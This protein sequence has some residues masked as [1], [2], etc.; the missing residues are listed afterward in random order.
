MMPFLMMNF[1]T[2]DTSTAGFYDRIIAARLLRVLFIL[3][4]VRSCCS[5]LIKENRGCFAEDLFGRPVGGDP[6]RPALWQD[7]YR[8]ELSTEKCIAARTVQGDPKGLASFRDKLLGNCTAE[9]VVAAIGGSVTCGKFSSA[10]MDGPC[11]QFSPRPGRAPGGPFGPYFGPNRGCISEAWPARLEQ[12]LN[13]RREACCS[14]PLAKIR[15]ENFCKVI[16]CSHYKLLSFPPSFLPSFLPF[17]LPFFLF[18]G[19]SN[20]LKNRQHCARCFL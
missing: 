17:F 2:A 9:V 15:V 13:R 19:M 5:G 11:A 20:S 14:Q 18:V 6:T 7:V 10:R 3:G 16:L 12:I 8:E 4:A 1:G